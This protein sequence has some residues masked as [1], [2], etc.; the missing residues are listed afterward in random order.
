[1]VER[2]SEVLVA[3]ILQVKGCHGRLK[4]PG[5][6]LHTAGHGPQE[7]RGKEKLPTGS[8]SSSSKLLKA[9]CVCLNYSR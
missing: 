1:M 6:G 7:T 2:R 4:T 3:Y 9:A 5:Q 8:S